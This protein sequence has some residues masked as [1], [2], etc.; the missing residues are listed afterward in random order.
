MGVFPFPLF[1]PKLPMVRCRLALWWECFCFLCVFP[2]NL[3]WSVVDWLFHGTVS[4][5]FVFLK[6]SLVSCWLAL[7]WEW[8]QQLACL[9]FQD[10]W[11]CPWLPKPLICYLW[12]PQDYFNE[13]EK[14]LNSFADFHKSQ[15]MGT[16]K[17]TG[18]ENRAPNIPTSRLRKPWKS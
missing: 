8:T 6:P 11:A 15:K 14:F 17:T 7:S 18:F 5:S 1:F 10:F 16:R 2:V 13:I 4:V 12:G 3:P 9:R